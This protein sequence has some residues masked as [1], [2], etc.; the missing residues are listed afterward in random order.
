MLPDEK[1]KLRK[2]EAA[3]FELIE[4][5]D[6]DAYIR[7]QAELDARKKK[8]LGVDLQHFAKFFERLH[9]LKLLKQFNLIQAGQIVSTNILFYDGRHLAYTVFMASEPEAMRWGAATYH[10]VELISK[11]PAQC[12]MLDYC[13]ANVPEVAR[14]KAALGLKL[15]VFYRLSI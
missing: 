9:E 5:F 6:P 2:A 14:F 12:R 7:L 11:L 8:S 4:A 13:G 1:K 15:Q 10:S 3:G